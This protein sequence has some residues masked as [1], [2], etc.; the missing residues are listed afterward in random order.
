MY[1]FLN[2]VPK[3]GAADAVAVELLANG[4]KLEVERLKATITEANARYANNLAVAKLETS[5]RVIQA[6]ARA[7]NLPTQN[8]T[9][10]NVQIISGFVDADM[11][12]TALEAQAAEVAAQEK[13]NLDAFVATTND[14]IACLESYLEQV[15]GVAPTATA[16]AA[17]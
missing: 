10:L 12:A 8:N 4:I 15:E 14:Q 17:E 7:I 1:A 11:R 2:L 16:N 9:A 6:K 5:R 13:A 3:K